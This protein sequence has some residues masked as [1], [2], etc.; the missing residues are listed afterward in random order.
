MLSLS[1][2]EMLPMSTDDIVSHV[3]SL[4]REKEVFGRLHEPV[5]GA[6]SKTRLIDHAIGLQWEITRLRA[7][8]VGTSGR[9]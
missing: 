1:R 7:L 9:P 4:E 5:L 2:E 8:A 3:R 6:M